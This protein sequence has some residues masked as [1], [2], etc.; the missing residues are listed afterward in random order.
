VLPVLASDPVGCGET[1]GVCAW[2]VSHGERGPCRSG[3]RRERQGQ[4]Q[5]RV[6]VTGLVPLVGHF[7]GEACGVHEGRRPGRSLWEGEEGVVR[8]G[9][10]DGQAAC[11]YAGRGAECLS[12]L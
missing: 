7:V 5:R 4:G 1:Q 10:S 6:S 8:P 12:V 11:L 2:V 3:P 9:H